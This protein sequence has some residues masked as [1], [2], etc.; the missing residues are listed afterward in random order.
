VRSVGRKG[1]WLNHLRPWTDKE[2]HGHLG[3]SMNGLSQ[4]DWLVI[5][6]FA[7]V[8]LGTALVILNWIVGW[9]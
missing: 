5:A 9:Y 4:R 6:L 8:T 1:G 3:A 2:N 7:F